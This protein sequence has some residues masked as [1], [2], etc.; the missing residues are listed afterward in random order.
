MFDQE[1]QEVNSFYLVKYQGIIEIF[2]I[3]HL[4]NQ[5]EAQLSP[6]RVPVIGL[7]SQPTQPSYPSSSSLEKRYGKLISPVPG[8]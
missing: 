6:S 4:P 8:S 5:P 1:S 7:Y 3:I 2:E